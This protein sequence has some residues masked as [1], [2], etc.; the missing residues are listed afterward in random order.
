V[1]QLNTADES[2]A[3]RTERHASWAELFFDLVAVAGVS[4]LISKESQGRMW[5]PLGGKERD[6]VG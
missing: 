3:A 1:T 6:R 5:V 2:E 4:A